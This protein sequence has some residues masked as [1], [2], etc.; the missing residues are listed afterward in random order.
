MIKI[1]VRE[2]KSVLE[3][4]KVTK[5][6]ISK[7]LANIEKMDKLGIATRDKGMVIQNLMKDPIFRANFAKDYTSAGR[8]VGVNPVPVP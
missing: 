5:E 7:I 3:K 2:L 4:E 8:V 6:E 1:S